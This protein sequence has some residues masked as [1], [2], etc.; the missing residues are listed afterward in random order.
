MCKDGYSHYSHSDLVRCVGWRIDHRIGHA[1]PIWENCRT[2]QC[3]GSATENG[4][5]QLGIADA[6]ERT[7]LSGKVLIIVDERK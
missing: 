7:K 5:G 2:G 4:K 3:A 1:E 6:R